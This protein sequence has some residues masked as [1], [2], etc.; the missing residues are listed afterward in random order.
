M[1][2]ILGIDEVGRGCWAGPLVAGAVILSDDFTVPT[3]A[4]W[5]LNDSKV[6]SAKQRGHANEALRGLAVGYGLGWVTAAELDQIGLSTAVA[7]AMRR[8]YQNAVGSTSVS[9][10]QIIIDGA[11]NYLPDINATQAVVKADGSVP[12]VSA[13]SILAKV[14]RDTW[15][16]TEAERLFPG[17]GFDKHVGYGTKQHQQALLEFGVCSLHRKSFKPVAKLVAT[18]V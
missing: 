3:G 6:L 5:K 2:Y 14:A 12:A 9:V 17:Y 15:M 8:A 7:L 16:Q 18:G 4:L 13:A 10:A 1:A 11:V